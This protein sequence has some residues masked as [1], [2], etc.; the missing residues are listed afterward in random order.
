MSM[1]KFEGSLRQLKDWS[2]L[3]IGYLIIKYR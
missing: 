3:T 2:K 1:I